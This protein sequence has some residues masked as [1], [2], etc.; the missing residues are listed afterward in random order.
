MSTRF[1]VQP[2][3]LIGG[4]QA[5]FFLQPGFFDRTVAVSATF[6][7]SFVYRAGC[8]H[9]CHLLRKPCGDSLD[10][11]FTRRRQCR[12]G[13]LELQHRDLSFLVPHVHPRDLRSM[14]SLRNAFMPEASQVPPSDEL[15]R[16]PTEIR[17][18]A[19]ACVSSSV[20]TNPPLTL[21]CSHS[22]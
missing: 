12:R 19:L 1:E 10:C 4:A 3:S 16:C 11:P 7:F 18:R 2:P 22:Q 15:P 17:S 9:Q 13:D 20:V 8:Q 6:L 14:H 21:S 5:Y